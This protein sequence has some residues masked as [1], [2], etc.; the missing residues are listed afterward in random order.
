MLFDLAAGGH[1]PSYIRHLIN[2]WRNENLPVKLDIVVSPKFIDDHSDIVKIQIEN[3]QSQIRFISITLEEYSGLISKQ[4]LLKR[5]FK[6]WNLYCKYADELKAE[7]CLLMY[8]DTLQLPIVFGKKSPCKFSGIY[9]R[10]TFHYTDFDKYAFSWKDIFR[11]WRQKLLLSRVLNNPQFQYLFSL[12]KFAVKH[13][14]NLHTQAKVFHLADPVIKYNFDQAKI[15]KLRQKLGIDNDR[16]IFILFGKLTIRKG[17]YQLLEAIKLMPSGLCKKLSLLLVGSIS[18]ADEISIQSQIK[19]VSQSL[20]IQIITCYKFIAEEEVNLYFQ[21]ADVILAPYQKHVGMSG[22]LLLAAAA[23]KPVLAS[24][25]GLMGQLVIQNRLGLAVDSTSPQAIANGIIYFINN[26]QHQTAYLDLKMINSF[27]EE[28]SVK[29]F[30]YTLF[31]HI[32]AQIN[33]YV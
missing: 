23:E 33:D 5:Y 25:Y 31:Q 15:D 29:N 2:Y 18:S 6:E 4:F 20:P 16:K 9:F 12:D 27:I 30:S 21:L 8:L 24:N 11:R 3:D 28:N 22:I 19:I 13:I 1:H 32:Y 10:P 14:E 26:N 17:I 7:H